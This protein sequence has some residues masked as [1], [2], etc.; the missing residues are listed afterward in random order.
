MKSKRIFVSIFLCIALLA[1]AFLS[2]CNQDGPEDTP[3]TE[4][5]GFNVKETATAE[6]ASEYFFETPEV[7]CNGKAV[8]VSISVKF[9]NT[10][11]AHDGIKFY[12]EKEGTYKVTYTAALNGYSESKTTTV[13][14]VYTSGPIIMSYL[15]TV[16]RYNTSIDVLQYITVKG[17]YEGEIESVTAKDVTSE[18]DSELPETQF[19]KNNNVLRITDEDIKLCFNS[20]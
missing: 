5:K 6:A 18:D 15:P 17:L 2:A 4:F 3:K 20:L 7:T 13:N 10:T 9:G 19:D 8:D 12:I 1:A 16:L 11:I 14:A